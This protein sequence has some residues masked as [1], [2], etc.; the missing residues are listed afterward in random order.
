MGFFEYLGFAQF[1]VIYIFFHILIKLLQNQQT[2]DAFSLNCVQP[3][4]Q[5]IHLSCLVYTSISREKTL[6]T[7]EEELQSS[8]HRRKNSTHKR[9][10]I[11]FL[12]YKRPSLTVSHSTHFPFTID[13]G[14]P[15][16]SPLPPPPP[17]QPKRLV[18]YK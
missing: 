11:F 18:R 13:V 12:E 1:A 2:T 6:E 15:F 5:T 9:S 4:S 7:F 3:S 17:D 8:C 10:K 14:Y 16:P